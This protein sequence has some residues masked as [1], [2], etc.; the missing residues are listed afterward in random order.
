VENIVQKVVEDSGSGNLF[1]VGIIFAL[2]I[3]WKLVEE[4]LR[5][6]GMKADK[7]RNPG[8]PGH[9]CKWSPDDHKW[10]GEVRDCMRE[11]HSIVKQLDNRSS[12]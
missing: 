5:Y 8:N 6:R 3:I 9:H 10:L 4:V 11:I 2:F 7:N 1:Q 12:K